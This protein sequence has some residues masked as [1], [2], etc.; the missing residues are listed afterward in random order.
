MIS[1][2]HICILLYLLAAALVLRNVAGFRCVDSCSDC[3]CN[4]YDDTENICGK[5][6]CP[7]A[8]ACYGSMP[9]CECACGNTEAAGQPCKIETLFEKGKSYKREICKSSKTIHLLFNCSFAKCLTTYPK[10]VEVKYSFL[11]VVII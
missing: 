3:R 8:K 4:C 1:K 9:D 2:I 5:F 10:F 11:F 7:T 6:F